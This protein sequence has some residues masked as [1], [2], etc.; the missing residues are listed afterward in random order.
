MEQDDVNNANGT[1]AAT[2]AADT[3]K[4][5]RVSRACDRC[6]AK[7]DKCDGQRPSCSTCLASGLQCS[8][9]PVTKKRG[10]PEGYVR[11]LEKLWALSIA[12]VDGLEAALVSLL[13]F[14]DLPHIWNH[15]QVG[16]DLHGIWKESS[17]LSELE[18]LLGQLE[19]DDQ[20]TGRKRKRDSEEDDALGVTNPSYHR[21]KCF[22]TM[23]FPPER[24]P[25]H[26]TSPLQPLQE[27]LVEPVLPSDVTR[28]LDT[29]FSYTHCWLPIL[30]RHSVLRACYSMRTGSTSTPDQDDRTVFWAVLAIGQQQAG[31]QAGGTN[32]PSPDALQAHVRALLPGP[33]GPFVVQHI[34]A[35]TILSLLD[36]G[37]G[38]WT[39]A[40]ITIGQAVRVG[41]QLSLPSSTAQ[42]D[43]RVLF[44]CFI[45]ETIIAVQIA[46]TPHLRRNDVEEC[47][48]LEEDE[49]EEWHP[50]TA[51]DT[52]TYQQPGAGDPA[53]VISCFN[54]LLEVI[55]V[56]NDVICNKNT[57]N[58]RQR[59][60]QDRE[61]VLGELQEKIPKSGGNSLSW[62]PPHHHNLRMT[63]LSTRILIIKQYFEQGT[64]EQRLARLSCEVMRAFDIYTRTFSYT[65]IPL[66][67]ENALCSACYAAISAR[68]IWDDDS[69]NEGLVSYHN[70][71]Q[72]MKE[73]CTKLAETW[74]V[75]KPLTTLWR[76]ELSKPPAFPD[77]FSV[78]NQNSGRQTEGN[79]HQRMPSMITESVDLEG[80]DITMSALS[81]TAPAGLAMPMDNTSPSL[82]GD[83][84][85][86]F[87][88]NLAHLD[89]TEWTSNR[90]QGLQDF[91]FADES[92][93]QAFCNDTTRLVPTT[94]SSNTGLV[95]DLAHVQWPPPGFFGLGR[96]ETD[97]EMQS[98]DT[99]GTQLGQSVVD[100]G[101]GFVVPESNAW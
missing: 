94:N 44:G 87:F 88:Y 24:D 34:Q 47:G 33:G 1:T 6:R 68:P 9:D 48:L 45:L 65:T 73:H 80:Y 92:T 50:W 39:S 62:S 46:K 56:V 78:S 25:V 67:L 59:W 58:E 66:L 83:D 43:K 26:N 21:E 61:R 41:L 37:L 85:D 57:G 32:V 51:A 5:K 72:Q 8:Y 55:M 86:A 97:Q 53:F 36:I 17:V 70:F 93:F 30:Q 4:R 82:Q 69:Q 52:H 13:Q 71:A 77:P 99:G 23:P 3:I 11:G 81:E 15:D 63:L 49:P 10:L 91:G 76:K 90:Q 54:R 29:Y 28:L 75:F 19:Q 7:K 18:K 42:R 2:E 60:L 100:A 64:P 101:M 35:L 79:F 16:E 12:K 84:I 27:T 98:V 20:P 40:W 14:E 96:V 89:T 38:R 74:P 31:L 95:S 22:Q